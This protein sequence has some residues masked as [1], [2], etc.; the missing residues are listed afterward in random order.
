MTSDNRLYAR[1]ASRWVGALLV[2]G[3][4]LLQACGGDAEPGPDPK[5]ADPA[6][7]LDQALKANAGG[8]SA[9]AKRGFEAL[10]QQDPDNKLASYNLGVLAQQAGDDAAAAG[11]YRKTLALDPVYEPAL[12][13][14]AI[15]TTEQGDAKAAAAL[16]E[17]A[18]KAD[19]RD[20]NA[21]YNYGLLLR[22]LGNERRAQSEIATAI[23]LD[24]GLK[25]PLPT[26]SPSG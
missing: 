10:L 5:A 7:L 6:V 23:K 11:H 19:P 20:A 25:Q 2:S 14:L 9:G 24:P 8:D 12:Y 15:L 3:T 21:H 13:N 26:A 17:R 1:G 4:L 16:Y 22:R 18:I